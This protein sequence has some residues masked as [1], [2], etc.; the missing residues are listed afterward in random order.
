[1]KRRE[2]IAGLGAVAASSLFAHAQQSRLP[3]V[4]SLWTAAD[5]DAAAAS[6]LPLLK[7]LAELGYEPGKTFI[8]EERFANEVPERFGVLANEL[9]NLKVDVLISQAGAP[10]IA[11]SRATSTIPIVAVGVGDP[12]AQGFAS[13]LSKP[14]GNVSGLSQMVELGAKRLQVLQQ[15]IPLKTPVALLTDLTNIGPRLELAEL[16]GAAKKL[17][18]PYE[19]FEVKASSDLDNAFQKMEEKGIKAVVVSFANILNTEKKRIADLGL[20]H[21]LAVLG[22]FYSYV[23][24]GALLSY[25]PNIPVLWHGAAYFIDKVLKGERVGDIPMQQPTKFDLS[26]NLQTAKA[27]GIEISPALLALADKVVE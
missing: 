1:M 9:V 19:V 6:R 26:I 5:A 27:L 14:G 23:E 4:G 15:A 7:G 21:Q 8:F 20:K 18:L 16:S 11:L 17:S 10:L 2:F 22:P 24:A 12:V 25:G 3:V 13:S